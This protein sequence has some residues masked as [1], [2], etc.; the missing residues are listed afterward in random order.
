MNNS[1]K[2]DITIDITDCNIYDLIQMI[3][4]INNHYQTCLQ[5]LITNAYINPEAPLVYHD[6]HFE[7]GYISSSLFSAVGT[8]C[9]F[10]Y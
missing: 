5:S 8:Y 7:D 6:C 1:L 10:D 9:L 4:Q 2:N 3:A